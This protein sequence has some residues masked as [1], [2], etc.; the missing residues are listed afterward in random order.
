MKTY[1]ITEKMISE[2]Q[3]K[4]GK[5][6]AKCVNMKIFEILEKSNDD[7]KINIKLDGQNDTYKI[8]AGR[9]VLI[10]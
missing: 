3:S 9:M 5:S 10:Q 6:K 4:T 8:V 2:M 1:N 7:D